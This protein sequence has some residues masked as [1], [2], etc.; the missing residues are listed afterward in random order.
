MKFGKKV[1][2]MDKEE[3]Y[4]VYSAISKL[5]YP[6]L[7]IEEVQEEIIRWLLE[8]KLSLKHLFYFYEDEEETI[9][10]KYLLSR[11]SESPCHCCS[12]LT[13]SYQDFRKE[14]SEEITNSDVPKREFL[15]KDKNI[16]IDNIRKT[17]VSKQ[18]TKSDIVLSPNELIKRNDN[19]TKFTNNK[20]IT[21]VIE[22]P[23]PGDHL[24]VN[25]NIDK[26]KIRKKENATCCGWCKSF[27]LTCKSEFGKCCIDIM[28][29]I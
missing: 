5:K 14:K 28:G 2:D 17:D 3:L 18:E 9:P 1:M 6:K 26:K 4:L 23:K 8:N 22:Q 29:N 24:K 12:T 25:T 11:N 19:I 21:A 13:T 27:C 15:E 16:L 20:K 7:G 10:H